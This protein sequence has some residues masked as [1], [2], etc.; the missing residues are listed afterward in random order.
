MEQREAEAEV[1]RLNAEHQDR[2]KFQWVALPAENGLWRIIKTPRGKRVDP[3]RA[4]TEAKPKPQYPEQPSTG[5][6]DN[7]PGYR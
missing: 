2:E 5:P 6:L 1:A 4:T 7:L 3:L